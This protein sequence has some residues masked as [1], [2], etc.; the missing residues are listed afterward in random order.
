MTTTKP[1]EDLIGPVLADPVRRARVEALKAGLERRLALAE[2]R[3]ARQLTQEQVAAAMGRPQTSVSRLERQGDLYVSTLRDY[4]EAM[5]AEL[6][7][8]AV[9][10]DGSRVP[11]AAGAG[12]ATSETS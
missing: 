9:F 1:I 10:P 3:R 4:V 6:E 7:V 11:I 5:G 2:V 8:A 12:S